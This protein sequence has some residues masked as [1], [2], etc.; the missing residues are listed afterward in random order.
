MPAWSRLSAKCLRSRRSW[1]C[2]LSVSCGG[3]WGAAGVSGAVG[4]CC[5]LGLVAVCARGRCLL[6]SGVASSCRMFGFALFRRM[7]GV[8]SPRLISG[9]RGACPPASRPRSELRSARRLEAR[10]GPAGPA[11]TSNRAWLSFV[12]CRPGPAAAH[13]RRGQAP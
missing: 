4:P 3:A 8:A 12:C 13:R 2:R 11:A 9:R 6:I 10:L 1:G 7:F 5:P